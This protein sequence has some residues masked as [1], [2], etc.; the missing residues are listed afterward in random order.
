MTLIL[1]LERVKF[2][3]YF[4]PVSGVCTHLILSLSC[5]L[6][7]V[8]SVPQHMQSPQ[9]PPTPTNFQGQSQQPMVGVMRLMPCL[10]VLW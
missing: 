10:N 1:V 7:S 8:K 2:L 9:Q 4:E 6:Q 5:S 3:N